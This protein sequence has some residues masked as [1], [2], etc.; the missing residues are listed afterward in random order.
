MRA[1]RY[2]FT[3][4]LQSQESQV[5]IIA[6]LE[7]TNRELNIS[8]SDGGEPIELEGDEAVMLYID[9]PDGTAYESAESVDKFVVKDENS[10]YYVKIPFKAEMFTT[11]GVYKFKLKII[12]ANDVKIHVWSPEFAM[13]VGEKKNK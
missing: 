8:F 1:S 9:R 4:D 5:C 10:R 11:T 12:E 2:N 13:I 6:T 3:L 7:D